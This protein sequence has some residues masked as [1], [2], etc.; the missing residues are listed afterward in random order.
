MD[1]FFGE[2]AALLTAISWSFTAIFFTIAAKRI[3]AL[4]VNRIR[5][6]FASL[7][8]LMT[9]LILYGNLIPI[10]ID[11]NRWLWLGIS[12]IIGL[13]L[14]DSML[15]QAFVLIGTRL[16]MLLMSLVPIVS[17]LLAWIFLHERLAP[18]E[19]LA[20]FLTVAGISWVVLEKANSKDGSYKQKFRTGILFGLGG[21]FGQA[22]G[23]I[24]AKKGMYGDF[25]AL[26]ATLM[27]ILVAT[28]VFLLFTA[29]KKI[30]S[31]PTKIERIKSSLLPIL[32]GSF[33]GPFVGIWLSLIAIKYAN[34]GIASAL[35]A[36][37]PI[38]LLPLTR[39]IFK[40]KVSWRSLFG[41]VIAFGG[42][43]MI[44]LF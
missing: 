40:E 7:M 22:L 4:A 44:F 26:T 35:M 21:A 37:P 16:T 15:L 8:L 42:V 32:G 33:F 9:Q 34:I 31:S 39:W 23:L 10:H 24:A 19:I 6:Y 11:S 13:V 28:A 18:I 27:R 25:S 5:L 43:A 41:T 2:F 3:G 14:G 36:L 1:K 30:T 20:I 29:I 12:G 38:F 17:T